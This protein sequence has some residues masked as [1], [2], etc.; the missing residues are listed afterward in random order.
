MWRTIDGGYF[1][2]G[3]EL[4]LLE[5]MRQDTIVPTK[6]VYE[7]MQVMAYWTK[8]YAEATLDTSSPEAFVQSLITNKLLTKKDPN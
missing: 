8:V 3:S 2:A 5:A 4:D 7:F 1:F 6:D